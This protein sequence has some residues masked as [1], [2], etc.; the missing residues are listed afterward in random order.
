MNDIFK[1][2]NDPTR[3][4]ILNLLRKNDMTAGEI[5]AQFNMTA[6]SISH[7]LDK[8]KRAG[9]VTIT[10][11]GQFIRYSLNTSIVEDLLQYILTLKKI[12]E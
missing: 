6:P 2:L 1:A 8:L 9:L 10:K 4:E 5:A 7:H 12:K 3:R 11:N